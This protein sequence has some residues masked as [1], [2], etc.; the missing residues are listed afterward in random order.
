VEHNLGLLATSL[1]H[2]GQM[3]RAQALYAE[4]FAL[5]TGLLVQAYNKREWPMFLRSRGRWQDADA[6]ARQLIANANPVIQATG[7]IEAGLTLA[8]ANRFGDAAAAHNAALRL[9]RTAPGGPIAANAL[10]ALQGEISLR[11]AERAKGRATLMEVAKRVRAA[12][13]PDAWSQALF[14]LESL[15]RTARAV[16]DWELAGQMARQLVEH[17]PTWGG[18]HHALALVAEHD[19]DTATAK[20]EFALAVKY[21]PK[22][23]PNLAELVES[24]RKMK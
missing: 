5:P 21:W 4:G 6:A 7:H 23:D 18:A 22:A 12:P 9:L 16:G 14:T 13:G 3:K 2:Q 8:A 19:G 10:L 1:Q 24:R 15:A 17:D 20:T 11:T